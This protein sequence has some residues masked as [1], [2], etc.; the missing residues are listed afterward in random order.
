M[1]GFLPAAIAI[2][3]SIHFASA[4]VVIKQT[5]EQTGPMPLNTD[6]T[7]SVS[8]E[9]VRID[10]GK[11]ISTIVNSSSG[12]IVSLMHAQKMAMQLPKGT[13]DVV[14]EKAA[15]NRSST[16][17][18]IK[19]TG[20]SEEINGFHCEE[21]TGT[22]EGMNV[23][24]WTTQ[25]IRNTE[26]ILAQLEKLSGEADPFKGALDGKSIPGIPIRTVV[27]SPQIG[28]STMTVQSIEEKNIP[29][30]EFDVPADYKTMQMPQMPSAPGAETP[31]VPAPST[32][33]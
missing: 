8:G 3:T 1:N 28:K 4:G 20:K 27:E 25:D 29:A 15:E 14:K 2:I 23:T 18:D 9:D 13:L 7:I 17:P 26:E 19:P 6:M 16:K 32:G 21:Y 5:I 31:R 24:Y 11:D 33:N 22:Y 12:E 10:I 30:S